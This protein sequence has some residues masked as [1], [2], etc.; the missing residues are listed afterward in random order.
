MWSPTTGGQTY[1]DAA[2]GLGVIVDVDEAVAWANELVRD[3]DGA[4]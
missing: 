4:S 3:I 2:D 1:A